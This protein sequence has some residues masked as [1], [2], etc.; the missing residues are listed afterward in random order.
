MNNIQFYDERARGDKT[1]SMASLP[2][3]EIAYQEAHINDN[4]STTL[5]AVCNV[6]TVLAVLSLL[7]RLAARRLARTPLGWD[8]YLAIAAMVTL[9][10]QQLSQR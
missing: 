5:I 6:F 9:C 2:P 4:L 7:A 3:S 10:R 8:D 1:C